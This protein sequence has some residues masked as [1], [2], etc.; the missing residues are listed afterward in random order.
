[1]C[2]EPRSSLG[3]TPCSSY[4][5]SL[6]SFS[7]SLIISLF[8]FFFPFVISLIPSTKFLIKRPNLQSMK[9]LYQIISQRRNLQEVSRIRGEPS[10]RNTTRYPMTPIEVTINLYPILTTLPWT[11]HYQSTSSS[12]SNKHCEWYIYWYPYHTSSYHIICTF[13][14]SPTEFLIPL[15]RPCGKSQLLFSTRDHNEIRKLHKIT[16]SKF[17]KLFPV[18]PWTDLRSFKMKT[19]FPLY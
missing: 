18:P 7:L 12:S 8:L 4:S 10:G 19:Q 1:M 16:N 11:R 6:H 3:S 13:P 15:Y 14:S 2:Q 5:P 17:T 9:G